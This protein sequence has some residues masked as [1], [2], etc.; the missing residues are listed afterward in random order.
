MISNIGEALIDCVYA[1]IVRTPCYKVCRIVHIHDYL[2]LGNWSGQHVPKYMWTLT[3]EW[4][5]PRLVGKKATKK[6]ETCHDEIGLCSKQRDHSRFNNEHNWEHLSR[7][8]G[9]FT[10]T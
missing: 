3:V 6:K 5:M 4:H 9:I 10:L 8:M 2:Q 7:R 1:R